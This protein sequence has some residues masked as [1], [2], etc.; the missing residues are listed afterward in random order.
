ML[1]TITIGRALCRYS[2][3]NLTTAAAARS[4]QHDN[5][6]HHKNNT[7]SKYDWSHISG[8]SRFATED[9]VREQMLTSEVHGIPSMEVILDEMMLPSGSWLVKAD[10]KKASLLISQQSKD[11]QSIHGPL[12]AERV[13]DLT[14]YRTPTKF[15]IN[16]NTILLYNI[17]RTIETE[18]ISYL[19]EDVQLGPK[20]IRR[21]TN[22]KIITTSF[23]LFCATRDDADLA[24][25]RCDGMCVGGNHLHMFRYH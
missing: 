13:T 25:L 16:S 20:G 19:F 11:K 7:K 10:S 2:R 17:P 24:V 5:K 8:F 14:L 9:D 1:S 21:L 6:R 18:E 3:R 12:V 22:D 15:G 23:L 4:P